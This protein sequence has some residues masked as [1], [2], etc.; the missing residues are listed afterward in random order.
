MTPALRTWILIRKSGLASVQWCLP[1]A[2]PLYQTDQNYTEVRRRVFSRGGELL[3][4]KR[5]LGRT[6]SSFALWWARVVPF[7]TSPVHPQKAMWRF[8]HNILP[9]TRT[10]SKLYRDTEVLRIPGVVKAVSPYHP[11]TS[12]KASTFPHLKMTH[13]YFLGVL[14]FVSPSF[15]DSVITLPTLTPGVH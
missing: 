3:R 11:R 13:T 6:R 2:Q 15:C 9:L 1:R 14:P 5:G 8:Y 10:K 12:F 4:E 7:A